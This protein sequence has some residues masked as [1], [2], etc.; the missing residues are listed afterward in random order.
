MSTQKYRNKN[1][2]V[3]QSKTTKSIMR[4]NSQIKT[5][6]KILARI[7]NNSEKET[8]L[9]KEPPPPKIEAKSTIPEIE[10]GKTSL[11]ND[12]LILTKWDGFIDIVFKDKPLILGPV[13][14]NAEI[15]KIDGNKLNL[16][17]IDSDEKYLLNSQKDYIEKTALDYFGKKI[18]FT[19]TEAKT[20]EIK[21][22]KYYWRKKLDALNEQERWK[23]LLT[24]ST[25]CIE[26][27]PDWEYGY[28]RR[29]TAKWGLQNYNGALDD[30]NK[31]IEINN[32][33]YI[34]YDNR[35][36]VRKKLDDYK[37]AIDDFTKAIEIDNKYAGAYNHRGLAKEELEDYKGAIADFNIAIE[38]DT[39]DDYSYYLRAR[40]NSKLG[41]YENAIEDYDRAIEI[42]N[43]N[44]NY[45]II[46]GWYREYLG[47][48]LGALKDLFRADILNN[49]SAE[50][51]LER[52]NKCYEL[53]FY[54][55]AIENFNEAIRLKP[56][57][58]S[59]YKNRGVAK[60]QLGD[61]KG[62]NE[63]KLKAD[64]LKKKQQK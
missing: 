15:L 43:K 46:R 57:Y 59:A 4:V 56:E 2:K 55:L 26:Q 54:K 12:D 33:F 21:K 34:A 48:I 13:I 20:K 40:A 36:L 35:G 29:A 23:E 44:P 38:L 58:A 8:P 25:N 14:Q 16:T 45:Y 28:F 11:I 42:D 51:F 31:A 18:H 50:H 1:N 19:F 37:G 7:K 49:E 41:N 52:G 5:T 32:K 3:V 61:L 24:E 27:L 63:D 30:S 10:S 62:A 47:D 17:G 60:R 64:E 6:E 22:N 39:K 9:I 53:K